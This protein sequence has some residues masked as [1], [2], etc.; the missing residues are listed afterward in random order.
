MNTCYE[1]QEQHSFSLSIMFDAH[2]LLCRPLVVKSAAAAAAA[3][4]HGSKNKG[5]G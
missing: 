4:A 1:L 3:A 2:V 5:L